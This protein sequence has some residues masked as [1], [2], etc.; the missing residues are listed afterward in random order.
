[1]RTAFSVSAL[2]AEFPD[3]GACVDELWRLRFG[4]LDRKTWCET[5]SAFRRYYR[6][7]GRRSFSCERCRSQRFATSDTVLQG[8]RVPI[9]AWFEALI[10]YRSQPTRL[11]ATELQ[12]RHTARLSYKASRRIARIFDVVFTEGPAP[13][14]VDPAASIPAGPAADPEHYYRMDFDR[15]L[16]RLIDPQWTQSSAGA[17]A[18]RGPATQ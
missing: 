2:H 5:C 12:N 18:K 8:T 16:Q 17:R 10:L 3:D 14:G 9:R 13:P 1:M 11:S 6:I 4:P 15:D 7:S